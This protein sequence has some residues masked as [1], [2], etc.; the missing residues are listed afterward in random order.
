[1][2]EASETLDGLDRRIILATQEGLPLDPQ[3]YQ[4]IADKLGVPTGLIQARLGQ[5]LADGRLRRIAAV[6]NHYRLGYTA[7]GMSVWDIPDEVVDSI[8]EQVGGLDFVS[9]CY[10]RP[11]YLPEWPYN[12][13]AMVH[14]RSREEV[15][16]LVA[17]IAALLGDASRG[18]EVLFSTRILKKTGMRF[19]PKE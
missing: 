4:R 17:Q 14:G 9:H 15:E 18:H 7:N 1:M 2:C 11:R 8:G 10:R 19:S 16:A 6:P 13:F 12:F 5:M 3:P